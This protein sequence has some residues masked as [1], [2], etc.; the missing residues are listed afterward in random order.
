M[1][2]AV[3]G[4]ETAAILTVGVVAALHASNLAQQAI[5]SLLAFILHGFG[6]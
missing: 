1:S 4:A 2:R 6:V 3:H 5:H